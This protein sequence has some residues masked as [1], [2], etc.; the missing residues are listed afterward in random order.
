MITISASRPF[1]FRLARPVSANLG[2]R[3]AITTFAPAS[4][5]ASAQARPIPCPPPVTT[6][7]FLSSLNFSRYIFLLF[8]F[9][10]R[11]AAAVRSF[12]DHRTVLVET[13]QPGRI[14]RKPDAVAG[15]QAEFSDAARR[16][17]PEFA[18]VDIE[19]GV[20]AQM[21]GD[22]HGAGPAVALL[23]GP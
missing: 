19:E 13:M 8:L 20:A 18:G 15:F 12:P 6:A 3:S 14:G 7:V 10:W 23:A 2:S 21:L 11:G 17:H 4:A 16:Q 22:R 5:S 9:S 1:A